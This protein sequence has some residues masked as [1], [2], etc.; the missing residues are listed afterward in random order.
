MVDRQSGHS[1]VVGSAGG[2][3]SSF[4]SLLNPRTTKK[5]MAKA[6]MRKLTMVFTNSP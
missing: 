4:L 5:K 1:L 2:A 3:S 6:M